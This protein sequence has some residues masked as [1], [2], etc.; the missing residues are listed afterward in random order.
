LFEGRSPSPFTAPSSP[1]STLRE[2]ATA[3]SNLLRSSQISLA[4]ESLATGDDVAHA[5]F[6]LPQCLQR[7]RYKQT[8]ELEL[9]QRLD[10]FQSRYG[11]SHPATIDTARRLAEI[12]SLQGRYRAAEL[13]F[14]QCANC[15]L[16]LFGEDD[17]R[18]VHAFSELA[19]CF[20]KQGQFSKAEKLFDMVYLRASQILS[21]SDRKFLE[22]K[23]DFGHCKLFLGDYAAAEQAFREVLAIGSRFLLPKDALARDCMRELALTFMSQGRL[24][25]AEELLPDVMEMCASCENVDI[26]EVLLNRTLFAELCRLQGKDHLAEQILKEVREKQ[27][28]TLGREHDTTLSTTKKLVDTLRNLGRFIEGEELLRDATKISAK[29]LG[30]KHWK[31]SEPVEEVS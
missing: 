6:Q 8:E 2:I 10:D 1:A 12:L 20:I 24:S 13:L 21:S 3:P 19:C 9:T 16:T 5:M 29:V 4:G 25:E 26:C 28:L 18:T 11:I 23:T 14:K 27:T 30:E 31:A 7:K 22:I 17:P 15:L